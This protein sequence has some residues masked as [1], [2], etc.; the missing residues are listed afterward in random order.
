MNI[1]YYYYAYF[2]NKYI[3]R[4][5]DVYI[6]SIVKYPLLYLFENMFEW[7]GFERVYNV[8][9]PISYMAHI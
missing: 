4:I 9:M 3:K 5:V 8:P 7:W 1:L 2:A 6:D